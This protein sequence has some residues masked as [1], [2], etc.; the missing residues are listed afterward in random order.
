LRPA[1]RYAWLFEMTQQKGVSKNVFEATVFLLFLIMAAITTVCILIIENTNLQ[2]A[3]ILNYKKEETVGNYEVRQEA[4]GFSAFAHR[5]YQYFGYLSVS[6][7]SSTSNVWI[8]LEYW[9]NDT[10]YSSSQPFDTSSEIFFVIPKTDSATFYVG[11][12]NINEG[13]SET[14]T[15]IYHY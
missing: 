7:Y 8:R 13:A 10:L 11:N 2:V 14:L 5:S 9:F 6:G 12:N 4:G 3:E 15:V 1:K